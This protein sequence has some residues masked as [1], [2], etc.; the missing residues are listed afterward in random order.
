MT[1][2]P[3]DFI[4]SIDLPEEEKTAFLA[5]LDSHASFAVRLNPFKSR[6]LF[7]SEEVTPWCSTG[8]YLSKK[9]DLIKDPLFHAGAYVSQEA[10][11]MF[12]E[13]I[14]NSLDLLGGAVL[15]LF[16]GSGEQSTQIASLIPA[17]A[18][19]V[20]N[21]SNKSRGWG[22]KES[23]D[24]WG[25]SN[26]IVTN[27]NSEDY[28]LF[29]GA[30]DVVVAN[31]PSSEEGKFR[32][33][34]RSRSDWSLN[35]VK[36]CAEKQIAMLEGIIPCIK[37]GGTLV[38]SS[39][40]YN[41][42]ETVAILD[43][44]ETNHNVSN[45]DIDIS[46]LE[47]VVEKGAF[48]LKGYQFYPSKINGEGYFVTAVTVNG[49]RNQL[50]VPK[51]IKKVRVDLFKGDE[52]LMNDRNELYKIS[53][54]LVSFPS[55][56]VDLLKCIIWDLNPMKIGTKIADEMNGKL[57]FSHEL[58]FS[59]DLNTAIFPFVEVDASDAIKFL[60]KKEISVL[61]DFNDWGLIR[62][63]GL[64]LGLVKRVSNRLNNYYPKEFRI[65]KE[66]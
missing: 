58:A 48:R 10:S 54:E 21:E 43:W 53:D 9:I 11:S 29:E 59:K 15:D 33:S 31:A 7:Q 27:N 25:V 6:N 32:L 30:F 41:D 56:H 2:I 1:N 14:F 38:F 35:S 65:R 51:R 3:E 55:K 40:A 61:P 5:A 39:Y 20:A 36:K 66:F 17:S 22:V 18:L 37:D 64:N 8:R 49:G 16:A 57:K 46:E 50:K 4:N 12:L 42:Q 19:L 60:Q 62:Y 34:K 26:V 45:L 44:L 52:Y 24:K 28:K 63:K 47:G 13:K 23:L